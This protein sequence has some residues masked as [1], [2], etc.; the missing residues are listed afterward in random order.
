MHAR[1]AEAKN[2]AQA[3]EQRREPYGH[4]DSHVHLGIIGRSRRE[5]HRSSSEGSGVRRP[6]RNDPCPCG[7]GKKY[8]RCCLGRE[9]TRAEFTQELNSFALPLLRELGRYATQ[10]GGLAPEAIASERFGFWRLPLDR[11]RAARVVDYVIFD[12][13]ASGHRRTA[14]Q[15]YL[16]ERGPIVSP[17]WR[18][19]LEAW[20]EVSMRL[21]VLEN[22]SAG[23][24][25]CRAIL[26][27]DGR[28]IEVMPLETN[29]IPLVV[30]A[31]LAVRALPVAQVSIY[32]AWPV[33]F[34]ER[35]TTDVA[36]AIVARHHAY[37]R[38][39][40]IVSLEEFLRLDSTAFDE[41][42]AIGNRPTIIVPGRS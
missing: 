11:I 4:P 18:S 33:T 20:Q 29:G 38:R 19:L 42:A 27:D 22:W 7:S 41:E 37:V 15:E 28:T 5:N 14:V 9:E 36:A 31:P 16:A 17:Q 23:F 25:R 39:E 34:G 32:P 13:R 24:A 35:T 30:G 21:F 26:P 6:G 12:Y 10:R 40:R 1:G 8:K 2:R 3:D